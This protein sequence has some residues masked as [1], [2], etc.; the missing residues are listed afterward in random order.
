MTDPRS[1]PSVLSQLQSFTWSSED[2][3][4][5]EAAIEAINGAV[6]AYSAL[7]VAEEAKQQPD[8]G[9][10][11]AAREGRAEC[12][13]WREQLDPADRTAVA[14]TR[15]RFSQLAEEVRGRRGE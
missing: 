12:A 13:R 3:V 6:G 11:A 4:A 7:I 2:S 10:L 15:R 1:E 14:E 8:Q 9:V 5:Y